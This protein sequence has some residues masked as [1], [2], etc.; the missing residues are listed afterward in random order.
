MRK[1]SEIIGKKWVE[2][3]NETKEFLLSDCNYEDNIDKRTGE[4][5]VDLKI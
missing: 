2:L 4:C 1:A 3:D 5:I